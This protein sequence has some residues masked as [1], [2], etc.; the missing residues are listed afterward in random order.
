[1]AR[2]RRRKGELSQF[3]RPNWGPLEDLVGEAVA[4][5]FMWMHEVRLSD[6]LLL[7]AYKHIDT[8]RYVHL[9]SDGRAFYYEWV[10]DFKDDSPAYYR[11]LPV[12]DAFEAVFAIL[13]GLAGV[14]EDQVTASWGAVAGL[15]RLAAA[16]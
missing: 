13:E 14:T 8:R 6:G 16:G 1:M 11:E 9:S 5:D 15:R 7:Q 3:E 10:E 4:C 2:P 12:V